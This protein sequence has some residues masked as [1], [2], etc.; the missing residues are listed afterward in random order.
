M[1]EKDHSIVKAYKKS[2]VHDRDDAMQ[3]RETAHGFLHT[4]PSLKNHKEQ[5]RF[6]NFHEWEIKPICTIYIFFSWAIN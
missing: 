2:R 6:S 1:D 3:V 4:F 5:I